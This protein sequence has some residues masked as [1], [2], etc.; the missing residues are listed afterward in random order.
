MPQ[1]KDP[2]CR[3]NDLLVIWEAKKTKAKLFEWHGF[4]LHTENI[5]FQ[6]IEKAQRKGLITSKNA[7]RLSK[8]FSVNLFGVFTFKEKL[9]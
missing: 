4:E 5:R 1:P 8:F 7:E 3:V 9:I 6:D 2:R